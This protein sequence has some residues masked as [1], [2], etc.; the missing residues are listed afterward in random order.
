MHQMHLD[1]ERIQRALHRELR[2]DA[3]SAVDDH[4]SACPECRSRLLQAQAEESWILD[5]LSTLDHVPPPV[6]AGS[7]MTRT[8]RAAPVWTRLAAGIVLA[9]GVAGVA[10]AVPGSPLPG[11]LRRI[12]QLIAPP[13][14]PTLEPIPA[15]RSAEP[16]AGIAVVPGARLVIDIVPGRAVDTAVVS[17]ADGTEVVVTAQGGATTFSSDPDRLTIRRSGPPARLEMLIPRQAPSISIR[18]GARRIWLKTDSRILS[19]ASPDSQG[20]YLLPLSQSA[21]QGSRSR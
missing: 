17:L 4:L 14:Q 10:Y 15:P 19:D 13:R 5:R 20:R 16:Q 6:T 1:D 2:P 12:V 18:V 7:V 9:L 21:H 3:E 8:H 11:A